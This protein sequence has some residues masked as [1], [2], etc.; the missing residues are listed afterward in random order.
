M[1]WILIIVLNAGLLALFFKLA[2]RKNLLSFLDGGKWWLTWLSV[3]IITLMD[4]LTSIFYVPAE[5][6]LL[7]GVAAFV[8]IIATSLF[9]RFLSSRMVEIAH[10]LEHHG[11]RGGGVY[12]FSYL[13]LGP[14]M[15][16]AAVASILVDYILTAAIS[17]VSA[18][19]NGSSFFS[20]PQGVIYALFFVAIWAVAFLNIIGIRENA[21]FT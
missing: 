13:V 10:I 1:K 21:R 9:I 20:I 6:Y 5:S 17:T 3:A 2:K 7:V 16:F 15:S 11:I 19:Y 12:S 14:T 4:E 8:F 18:V